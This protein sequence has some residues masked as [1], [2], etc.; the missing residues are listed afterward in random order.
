MRADQRQPHPVIVGCNFHHRI[1]Q[2]VHTLFGGDPPHEQHVETLADV[3]PAT[4]ESGGVDPVGDGAY[5]RRMSR[6]GESRPRG[7]MVTTGH[8]SIGRPHSRGGLCRVQVGE[9]LVV[10]VEHDRHPRIEHPD[11]SGEGELALYVDHV[12]SASADIDRRLDGEP[13]MGENR[14]EPWPPRVPSRRQVPEHPG[15]DRVGEGRQQAI[16]DSVMA[17]AGGPGS[18]PA[19]V[20]GDLVAGPDHAAGHFGTPDP[21]R[22]GRVRR[23]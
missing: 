7:D 5:S 20:D 18:V 4:A 13:E 23:A 3:P 1:D 15:H 12:G 22:D 6:M 9:P 8:D 16:V 2:R 17:L 19:G 14:G 10:E 11:H 21:D